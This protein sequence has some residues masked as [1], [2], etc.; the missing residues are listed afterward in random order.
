MA[1]PVL[2]NSES[3]Q[4]DT[5]DRREAQ[6]SGVSGPGATKGATT[7]GGSNGDPLVRALGKLGSISADGLN[8]LGDLHY[9]NRYLEGQAKAGIIES[10]DEIQGN[11]LTRDWELAG[12]RDTMGKLAIADQKAQFQAD[13][14]RLRTLGKADFEEYMTKRRQDFLP[15]F[16][17]MS[18]DQQ[19]ALAGQMAL[20]DRADTRTWAAEHTKYIIEEKSAAVGTLW[21]TA[22]QGIHTAQTQF[23]LGELPKAALDSQIESTVGNLVGAVWLDQSLPRGVQRQLTY[24]AM[25]QALSNDSLELYD[26]MAST[27]MDDSEGRRSTLLARLP[28]EDQDKLADQYRAARTRTSDTRN[29]AFMEQLASVEAQVADGTFTG[30]YNSLTEF[31]NPLVVR[32]AISGEKRAGIIKQFLREKQ[33]AEDTS[34]VAAAMIRGDFNAVVGRGKSMADGINAVDQLLYKTGAS[35]EQRY[36]TYTRMGLNGIKE[37]WQKAG[38]QAGIAFRQYMNPNGEVLTQHKAIIDMTLN[39]LRKAEQAGDMGARAFLLSGMEENDRMFAERMFNSISVGGK[40]VEQAHTE[41][42]QQ[43]EVEAKLT[44]SAKAALAEESIQAIKEITAGDQYQNVFGYAWN[45]VKSAFNDEEAALK[46]KILPYSSISERDGYISTAPHILQKSNMLKR[47][48]QLELQRTMLANPYA[49]RSQHINTAMAGVA[50]RTIET[51]Y[52]NMYIPHGQ[53]IED[54]FGVSGG[55]TALVG[56]AVSDLAKVSHPDS[57]SAVIEFNGSNIQITSLNKDGQ[58]DAANTQVLT[59]ADVSNRIRQIN[60]ANDKA[61]Q[62]VYGAGQTVKT[63]DG[64][65][66]FNGQNTA[67]VKG[68]WMSWFREILVGSEGVRTKPYKD[69]SGHSVGVGVYHTNPHYPESAK[70]GKPISQKELNESFK[71]ASDDAAKNAVKIMGKYNIPESP[72]AIAFLGSLTYQSGP[73]FAGDGVKQVTPS[74][75]VQQKVLK[76]IS[77]G[78]KEKAKKAFE[79]TAAYRHSGESRRAL[80]LSLIDRMS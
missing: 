15:D 8:K 48:L 7:V 43:A 64:S 53:K 42:L 56:R 26:F 2:R 44:P 27:V 67:G 52:G 57:G 59:A 78:E 69:A 21:N 51:E 74:M 40:S 54:L 76:H 13:I 11:P 18:R 46:N 35:P 62:A 68:S 77:N 12:Y 6:W 37:G 33:Q 72:E 29:L 10:E 49:N 25:N 55:N 24:Q 45:L 30:T 3:P 20:Q 66:T 4:F 34:D 1:G 5:T 58:V 71:N 19:A 32:G 73:G 22:L 65:V 75:K 16:H 79:S 50:A 9:R 70:Q 17:S 60:E 14:G 61:A 41:A 80:Y 63:K 38:Q 28:Q 36:D 39:N 23:A 47:E 31:L